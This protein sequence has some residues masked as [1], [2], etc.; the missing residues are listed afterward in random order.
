MKLHIVLGKFG[1][2]AGT[3]AGE[4]RKA[5]VIKNNSTEA[6]TRLKFG[7]YYKDTL[8]IKDK[9]AAYADYKQ[10]IDRVKNLNPQINDII[11][12]GPLALNNINDLNK[13]TS[14]TNLYNLSDVSFMVR[15]VEL[16]QL[17][18]KHKKFEFT[19]LPLQYIQQFNSHRP[20]NYADGSMFPA[21][22]WQFNYSAGVKL[23]YKGF[24]AQLRPEF[25]WAFNGAFPT[26]PTDHFNILWRFHYLSKTYLF[27]LQ[28][29]LLFHYP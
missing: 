17:N 25:N 20:L 15:P 18:Q 29:W 14:D 1:T 24:T 27:E 2:G 16:Q 22:G 4:L 3:I 23:A 10:R 11:I 13:L 12:S 5:L 26:F 19:V 6:V 28:L 9:I 7:E 21:R 8:V